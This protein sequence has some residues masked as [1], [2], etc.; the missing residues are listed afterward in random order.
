MYAVIYAYQPCRSLSQAL[1]YSI[2][3]QNKLVSDYL[4]LLLGLSD[5]HLQYIDTVLNR[6]MHRKKCWQKCQHGITLKSDI[7]MNGLKY[8]GMQ[9]SPSSLQSLL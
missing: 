3:F 9:V 6:Y 2:S 1:F 5:F 7:Y 4:V 8:C